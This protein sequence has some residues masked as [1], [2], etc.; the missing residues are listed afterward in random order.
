MNDVNSI[1]V[2]FVKIKL[3]DSLKLKIGNP[4]KRQENIREDRMSATKMSS[5]RADT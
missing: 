4:Y 2:I 3:E 5:Y 1:K